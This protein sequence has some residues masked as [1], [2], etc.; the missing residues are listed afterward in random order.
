MINNLNMKK[1]NDIKVIQYYN[2]KNILSILLIK[3]NILI[4]FYNLVDYLYKLID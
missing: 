4:Y 1:N 2:N 3:N